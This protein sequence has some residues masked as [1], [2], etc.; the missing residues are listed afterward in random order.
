[1]HAWIGVLR[2][3]TTMPAAVIECI[4]HVSGKVPEEVDVPNGGEGQGRLLVSLDVLARLLR[5]TDAQKAVAIE[6][7]LHRQ[8]S[9]SGESP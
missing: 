2:D 6:A 9:D 1:M 7:M 8:F 5:M 4:L 3:P